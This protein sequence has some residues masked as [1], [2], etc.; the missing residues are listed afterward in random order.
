MTVPFLSSGF[1][2]I[3]GRTNFSMN[4]ALRL[5]SLLHL[6]VVAERVMHGERP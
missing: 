6:L 4:S 1:A 5:V 3:G 2:P